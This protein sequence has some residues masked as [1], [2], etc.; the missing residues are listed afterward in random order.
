MAELNS[1]KVL[2]KIDKILLKQIYLC[3][4]VLGFQMGQHVQYPEFKE[5]ITRL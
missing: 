5:N 2:K 4:R 3:Q 1:D